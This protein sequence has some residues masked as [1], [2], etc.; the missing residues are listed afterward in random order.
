MGEGNGIDLQAM[1]IDNPKIVFAAV[2]GDGGNLHLFCNGRE[3]SDIKEICTG[4]YL[5]QKACDAQIQK[6]LQSQ[7]PNIVVPD[8]VSRRLQS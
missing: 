1:L 6:I 3:P 5:L 2:K 8:S 4:Y 7:K